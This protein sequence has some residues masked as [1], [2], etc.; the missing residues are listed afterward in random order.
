MWGKATWEMFW[1]EHACGSVWGLISWGT[2]GE[3][4]TLSL[5]REGRK[6]R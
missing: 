1:G 6:A 3:S 2:A 4:D 5:L